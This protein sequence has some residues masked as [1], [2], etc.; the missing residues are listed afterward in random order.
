MRRVS[1]WFRLLRGKTAG[2]QQKVS[3]VAFDCVL[4]DVERWYR[5]G[6]QGVPWRA[7]K[8]K[9]GPPLLAANVTGA[10]DM[11]RRCPTHQPGPK[12]TTERL[13]MCSALA[14]SRIK[15]QYISSIFLLKTWL[16]CMVLPV[17]QSL[18]HSLDTVCQPEEVYLEAGYA[19]RTQEMYT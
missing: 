8:S 7:R 14:L 13:W 12:P 6:W 4:S 5:R 15:A 17:H 3:S 18:R 11:L 2:S 19:I 16:I 1:T 9:C 10:P